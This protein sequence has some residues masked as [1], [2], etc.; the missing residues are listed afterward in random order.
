[1]G[2][3][4]G[5]MVTDFIQFWVAM[6]G[7]LVLGWL[8]VDR[9][10]GLESL[11]SQM[12]DLYGSDRAGAMM[13]LFPQADAASYGLFTRPEFWLLI[14]VFWWSY[15]FTDGGS[16]FAQRMLSA[17]DERQA[18]LGYLWYGGGAH[19]CGHVPPHRLSRWGSGWLR[20]V[21]VRV[22]L[23]VLPT[24]LLGLMVAALF[25]A[26]MS[27]ISTWVNLGASYLINDVYRYGS[28]GSGS[29]R[30]S[31]TCLSRSHYVPRLS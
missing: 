9:V 19:G 23:E 21:N 17:R 30:G 27:T 15:A 11:F 10:G 8:A 2:G 4:W 13:A 16:F 18:A 31:K 22:M 28:N 24:G 6:I 29:R 1:M 14:L 26:Y 5:V 3:L 20:Q 25:A 12:H 7:C